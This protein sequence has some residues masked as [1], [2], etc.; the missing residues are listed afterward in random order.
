MEEK[1]L[2]VFKKKLHY[3]GSLPPTRQLLPQATLGLQ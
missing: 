1:P 2:D 3:Q